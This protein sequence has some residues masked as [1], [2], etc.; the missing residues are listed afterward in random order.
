MTEDATRGGITWR[1]SRHLPV[2]GDSHVRLVFQLKNA[3]LY[4]FWVE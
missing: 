4:A 3:K 2:A 1:E